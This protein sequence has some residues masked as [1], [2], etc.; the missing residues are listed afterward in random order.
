MSSSIINSSTAIT[1]AT[2]SRAGSSDTVPVITVIGSSHARLALSQG[3]SLESVDLGSLTP[4]SAPTAAVSAAPYAA[5]LARTISEEVPDPR[6]QVELERLNTSTDTINKLEVELDE[7]RLVFRQLLA[8]STQRIDALSKKLGKC[9]Q[10][11]R[12]YY[13]ARIRAKQALQDTQAACQQY[14]RAV[15]EHSA[16]REMVYLAEEGL[17]QAGCSFDHTWQEMLNHAS[18]KVNAAETAKH[19]CGAGHQRISVRYQESE[20]RV[21]QLQQQLKRAIARSSLNTRR[22]LLQ[23]SNIVRM[24]QLHLL[25]YFEAKSQVNQQLEWQK[26]RVRHLE[27]Q[28]VQAKGHYSSALNTLEKISDQIH[29]RR[30]SKLELGVRG[31]GVGAES[32]TDCTSDLQELQD[33]SDDTETITASA[34]PA[35]T[36]N[37]AATPTIKV[38][39]V[40]AAVAAACITAAPSNVADVPNV[41]GPVKSTINTDAATTGHAAVSDVAIASTE[42]VHLIVNEPSNSFKNAEHLLEDPLHALP[43]QA[44]SLVSSK[45]SVEATAAAIENKIITDQQQQ[46]LCSSNSSSLGGDLSGWQLV[47]TETAGPGAAVTSCGVVLTVEDASMSDSESLGSIEMLSD[48]AIAGL[49][50]EDDLSEGSQQQPLSASNTPFFTPLQD[51]APYATDVVIVTS[52][53]TTVAVAASHVRQSEMIESYVNSDASHLGTDVGRN[54]VKNSDTSAT[55]LSD[56]SCAVSRS[57][58]DGS[59]VASNSTQPSVSLASTNPFSNTNPFSSSLTSAPFASAQELLSK[60][61]SVISS[62]KPDVDDSSEYSNESKSCQY[63]QKSVNVAKPAGSNADVDKNIALSKTAISSGAESSHSL[64]TSGSTIQSSMDCSKGSKNASSSDKASVS[65]S[66][67][68]VNRPCSLPLTCRNNPARSV[69][70]CNA[71]TF[72][73]VTTN[74]S[75]SRCAETVVVPCDSDFPSSSGSSESSSCN[76]YHAASGSEEAFHDQKSGHTMKCANSDSTPAASRSIGDDNSKISNHEGVT[77]SNSGVSKTSEG[78]WSPELST[79]AYHPLQDALESPLAYPPPN[80]PPPPPPRNISSTISSSPESVTSDTTTNI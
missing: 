40:A 55:T 50:L 58:K 66:R 38:N 61:D 16:A 53:A 42:D 56:F 57:N 46:Q 15:G 22:S 78:T 70:P 39:T 35:T 8:D 52:D 44:V 33:H 25:P 31:V 76:N 30:Q 7:A 26:Q 51:S 64:S 32:P 13:E 41:V 47:G 48:D 18:A 80:Y 71:S 14:E 62:T 77:R 69:N 21:Q 65:P 27:Q 63:D 23:L 5:V 12:P 10:Q 17:M 68:P 3:G 73:P 67:S 79:P 59:I 36:S 24:Q 54:K 34:I 37:T 74:S 6:I 1:S 4:S 29:K 60:I 72:V 11:A 2:V 19:D 49:M 9:V 43:L 20:T 28:V 45:G 75:K